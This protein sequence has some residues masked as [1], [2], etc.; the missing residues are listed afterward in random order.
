M[1]NWES[2]IISPQASILEALKIIDNSSLQI[3]LVVD[4][5]RKLL[6]TVTDG[7]IRR[8]ILRKVSLED[9]VS[10]IMFTSPTVASIHD[11]KDKIVS[12]M[13]QND[14]SHIPL[15]D[16]EGR[17][18]GIKI[19]VDML[20]PRHKDTL[21]ILMAGG[22]GKRLRPLTEGSPKPMLEIGGK[23]LLETILEGFVN[24]GFSRFCISVNY[25]ADIIREH[26][27]DGSQRGVQISYLHEEEQM[28]TVG[29]LSLLD[30]VPQKSFIVMNGDVLTKV[31]FEQLLDF[32]GQHGAAATMCVRKYDL[33]VP[34]GVV[35]IEDE[36]LIDIEEK[37]I[38]YFFVNA[39][40]YVLEPEILELIPRKAYFDMPALFQKIV[41]TGREVR[42]FPIHEYWI[43]LGRIEDMTR[44]QGEFKKIFK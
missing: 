24:H 10:S 40:I 16:A 1:K 34:Y 23:P 28:G 44:A 21:V 37:P 42:T 30:E 3:A 8:A 20:S 19:M 36:K 39:G 41:A 12:L 5:N 9:M 32:H 7:D 33:Q 25:K 35:R 15:I 13:Y 11:D 17:V 43:D 31:N 18:V 14:L 2:A 29:S 6:G 27:G 22:L 4:E 38:H 26:F